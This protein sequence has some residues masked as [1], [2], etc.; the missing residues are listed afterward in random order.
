MLF[1]FSFITELII[2]L[3]FFSKFLKRKLFISFN[4]GEDETTFKKVC[5]SYHVRGGLVVSKGSKSLRFSNLE[6]RGI[7]DSQSIENIAKD[8]IGYIKG[9]KNKLRR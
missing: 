5:A 9:Y 1:K 7:G 8:G 6:K 4:I 2:L 3:I